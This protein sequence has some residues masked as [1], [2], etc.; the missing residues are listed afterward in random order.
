MFPNTLYGQR[1]QSHL[2]I[3]LFSDAVPHVLKIS[4]L[5]TQSAFT[6]I[7]KGMDWTK[8]LTELI[9]AWNCNR[10]EPQV[11]LW[12]SFTP[13]YS[14]INC[15]WYDHNAEAFRNHSNSLCFSVLSAEMRSAY[16]HCMLRWIVHIR[17]HFCM[18]VVKQITFKSNCRFLTCLPG[19]S[20]TMNVILSSWQHMYCLNDQHKILT[21]H[22]GSTN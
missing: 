7:C 13:R 3:E 15:K 6:S 22:C 20:T 16:V 17:L 5:A 19:W 10:M 9:W 14:M 8:D 12:N 4:C 21:L 11:S 2:W 18:M 1:Y